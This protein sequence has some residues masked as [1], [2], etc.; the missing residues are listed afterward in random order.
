MRMVNWDG[1]GNAVGGED[2]YKNGGLFKID[3]KY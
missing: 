2:F 1:I 3:F